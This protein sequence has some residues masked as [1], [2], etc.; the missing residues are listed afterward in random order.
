MGQR[1][2]PF[3]VKFLDLALGGITPN[4]LVLIGAKTGI[5]KTALAVLVALYNCLRGR[6]V[7][8]YALEAEHREIERRMKFQVLAEKYFQVRQP[9]SRSDIRYLD[10]YLGRLDDL[11][12]PFEDWADR[13]LAPTLQ[14]LHTYYRGPSF[15]PAD[16]CRTLEAKKDH[17][18]LVVLDHL[19]YVDTDDENENRGYR[20]MVKRIRD[21]ALRIG[22]PV[23]A[24][25]HV[26]K[27]DRRYEPL[28]PTLEDFHGSSEIT[29]ISTKAIM[30]AAA[31]DQQ[32]AD[33]FLWNT[34]V[35][36]AKCRL[37]STVCRYVATC[38]FNAR[39]NAYEDGFVLG[40]LTQK[41]TV[42]DE[43]PRPDWPEWARA[44]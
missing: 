44:R 23:I 34:Y 38:R 28:V 9:G 12:S 32:N 4:D 10:W 25:A 36:V 14:H 13:Q 5:G 19:H 8:Y 37:D 16:F 20:D 2:L 42:F 29:K 24:V 43:L 35:Q 15:T 31:Y 3:G 39:I 27:G 33:S 26:R 40:R 11:L 41:G 7:Y 1:L 30:L 21:T 22:R 17:A 6:N 18:D